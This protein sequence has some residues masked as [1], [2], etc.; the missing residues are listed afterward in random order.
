MAESPE[1]GDVA[2]DHEGEGGQDHDDEDL[3]KVGHSVHAPGHG[4][5]QR[6]SPHDESTGLAVPAVLQLRKDDGVAHGH[7]AVQAD[8]GEEEQRAVLD[9]VNETQGGPDVASGQVHEV[10]QLQGGHQAE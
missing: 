1:D 10:D 2:E 5:G 9:A 6:E 4:V 7:V 8:A 3:F